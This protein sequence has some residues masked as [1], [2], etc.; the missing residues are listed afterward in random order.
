MD[1]SRIMILT[2]IIIITIMAVTMSLGIMIVRS[3]KVFAESLT[4]R[5]EDGYDYG[6]LD[7]NTL[8]GN[9]EIV[10]SPEF[11]KHTTAWQD[12]FI[13]ATDNFFKVKLPYYDF[14]NYTLMNVPKWIS[15][16]L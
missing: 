8:A 13:A 4:L 2:S 10:H 9:M 12:G 5:Y 11:L 6:N 15:N 1:N 14:D 7:G 3:H 16:S